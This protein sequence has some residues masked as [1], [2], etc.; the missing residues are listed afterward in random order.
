MCFIE[1]INL[2]AIM[3]LENTNIMYNGLKGGWI[4]AW[5]MTVMLHFYKAVFTIKI[6]FLQL[7][8]K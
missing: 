6:V 2:F 7:M 4:D 1:N 8:G 5:L 3:N